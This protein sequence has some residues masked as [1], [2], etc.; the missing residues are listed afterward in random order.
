MSVA[1][2]IIEAHIIKGLLE[3]HGIA[4][5]VGGF[6]LQGGVGDLAARDFAT[7]HVAD[8]DQRRAAE[9]ISE[10]DGINDSKRTQTTD[11][12]TGAFYKMLLVVLVSFLIIA[13]YS[14]IAK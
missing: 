3:S 6:Y 7:L 10:Y 11:K 13:I 12:E 2:D 8:E 4:A 1:R 14:F 5:H 9:I